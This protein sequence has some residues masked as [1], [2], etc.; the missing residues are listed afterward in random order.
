MATPSP[1]EAAD[2]WGSGLRGASEKIRRGVDRVSDSPTKK[3]AS[4]SEKW[5]QAV[6]SEDAL[7]KFQSN[8]ESVSLQDWKTAFKNTGISRISSG[9]DKGQNNMEEFMGQLLPHIE[10]GQQKLEGMPDL[11]LDDSVQ[12]M[13]EFVRHMASFSKQ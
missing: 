13:T 8:L 5:R 3:A 2:N 1:Q 4:K 7:Q 12:R 9:V 11:T 6:S 10:S